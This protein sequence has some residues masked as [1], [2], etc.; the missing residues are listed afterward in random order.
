MNN[1]P[2]ASNSDIHKFAAF[3]LDI[4]QNST[5]ER[6]TFSM[7]DQMIELGFDM[8]CG[9]AFESAY[10]LRALHNYDELQRVI[11][12]ITDVKILCSGIHSAYCGITHWWTEDVLDSRNREWFIVAL[13]RLQ[14]LTND[15]A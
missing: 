4:F 11:D 7:Q 14:Q 9:K 10:G 5:D 6:D 3:W 12:R 2:L 8:D 1:R 13:L 15:N